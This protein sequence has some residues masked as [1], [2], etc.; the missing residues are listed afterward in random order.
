EA[1]GCPRLTWEVRPG[2]EIIQ[3]WHCGLDKMT[4][5]SPPEAAPVRVGQRDW[6]RWLPPRPLPEGDAP[7]WKAGQVWAWSTGSDPIVY[8]VLPESFASPH[9]VEILCRPKFSHHSGDKVCMYGGTWAA[10]VLVQD[11]GQAEPTPPEVLY[12]PAAS[13]TAA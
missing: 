8:R 5:L 4:Y 13:P 3:M 6:A 7:Q 1:N 2:E 10:A 11:V 9:K 12:A